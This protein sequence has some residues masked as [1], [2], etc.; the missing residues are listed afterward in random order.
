MKIYCSDCGH[1]NSYAS[2]KPNFCQNCGKQMVSTIEASERNQVPQLEQDLQHQEEQ[3][4]TVPSL[5][6]L[7]VEI[8]P[9]KARGVEFGKILQQV[10][11]PEESKDLSVRQTPKKEKKLSKKAQAEASKEFWNDFRKEAGTNRQSPE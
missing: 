2:K 4:E 10:M 9:A 6:G 11:S 1:P 7:D 3:P 5:K 8:E